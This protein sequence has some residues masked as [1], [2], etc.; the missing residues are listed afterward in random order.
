ML[1]ELCVFNWKIGVRNAEI[2]EMY[3]VTFFF[4]FYQEKRNSKCNNFKK[5][6]LSSTY[7]GGPN[8][9]I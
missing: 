1:H 8:I 9:L 6:T 4:F 7:I 2:I 5:S 3:L